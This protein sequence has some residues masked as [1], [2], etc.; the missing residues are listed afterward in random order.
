M[1]I[2]VALCTLNGEKFLR[3]QLASLVDQTMQIDE[4][5]VFD[6]GSTDKTMEILQQY[7]DRL[8]MQIHQNATRL[9]TYRNFEKAISTCTGDYIFPADQDDFWDSQK[10]ERIVTYLNQRTEID[11]AFTDAVLVDEF[12]QISGKRLWS[13]FRFREKQQNEWKAG[14]SLEILL[15]GNRVTGCTMCLRKS[16]F[17]KISPFPSN[18]PSYFLH[19]AWMGI[20]ASLEN[21]ISFIPAS[22]VQYR[23]HSEQQVGVLGFQGIPPTLWERMKR[24]HSEKIGP[25]EKKLEYLSQLKIAIAE[26]FPNQ[27]FEPLDTKIEYYNRRAKLPKARWQRLKK[28]LLNLIS[29]NYHRFKDIDSGL[30]APYLMFLGDLIE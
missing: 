18:M 27:S 10:I 16:F 17:N 28:T 15:D 8:P 13:T 23:Q 1:R 6:E 5:V 9:G 24:P 11:V 26:K 19:D 3:T 22:Y 25:Y 30:G 29:G 12:G 2:S 4:L 14:K 21:K 7:K 20:A